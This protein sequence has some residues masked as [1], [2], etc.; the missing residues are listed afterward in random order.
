GI[1]DFH[2]TGVQTCALPIL[3]SLDRDP[4]DGLEKDD[5]VTKW[6]EEKDRLVAEMVSLDVAITERKI[7]RESYDNERARVMAEA[8]SAVEERSEERRVGKKWKM[9]RLPT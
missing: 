1:R 7:D 3:K 2:V 4:G 8:E 5:R 6:R 9:E